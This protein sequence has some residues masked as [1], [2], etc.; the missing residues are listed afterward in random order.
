MLFKYYLLLPLST[1]LSLIFGSEVFHSSFST[2][3][4]NFVATVTSLFG[5]KLTIVSIYR[6]GGISLLFPLLFLSNWYLK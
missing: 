2:F 4:A 1:S 3:I 6:N 5:G